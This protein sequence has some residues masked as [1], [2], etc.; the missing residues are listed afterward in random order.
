MH[1]PDPAESG[2]TPALGSQ[3]PG[4]S[5][6]PI[7]LPSALHPAPIPQ[8]SSS[9]HPA[10]FIQHSVS[11]HPKLPTPWISLFSALPACISHCFQL[12]ALTTH[13]P[14]LPVLP[15]SI[16][17]RSQLFTPISQCSQ[18]QHPFSRASST[19]LPALRTHL[20][21]LPCPSPPVAPPARQ[22]CGA[23]EPNTCAPPGPA[24]RS[25]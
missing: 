12:P 24:H 5:T 9:R 4:P 10:S 20:P 2:L 13:L 25:Q 8:T 23:P 3:D 16:F 22:R 11:Q 19:Q 6:I 1:S 14:V 17:Q 21:L 7:P 15:A 18:L